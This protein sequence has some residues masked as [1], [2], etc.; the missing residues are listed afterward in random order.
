MRSAKTA[1]IGETTNVLV[2]YVL[3]ESSVSI[4]PQAFVVTFVDL[5][6]LSTSAVP[7]LHGYVDTVSYVES[8][9]QR[10]RF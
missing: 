4:V 1:V 10:G 9:E 7:T 8:D 6:H 5:S 2:M 3:P